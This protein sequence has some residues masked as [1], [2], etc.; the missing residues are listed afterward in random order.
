MN[1]ETK[2]GGTMIDDHDACKERGTRYT[3]LHLEP[4]TE[5]QTSSHLIGAIVISGTVV[6]P[7]GGAS[8]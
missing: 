4:W 5:D 3:V 2:A 7:Q 6:T 8:L 1:E